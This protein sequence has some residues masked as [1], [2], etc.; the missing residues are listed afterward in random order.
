MKYGDRSRCLQCGGKIIL[1][2]NPRVIS[3]TAA[4]WVHQGTLRRM[5]PTHQAIG[6]AE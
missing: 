3:L 5:F 2:K 6:P 1:I 4:L